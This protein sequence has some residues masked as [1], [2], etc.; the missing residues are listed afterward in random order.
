MHFIRLNTVWE[1]GL[2]SFFFRLLKGKRETIVRTQMSVK[3]NDCSGEKVYLHSSFV[4]V[5]VSSLFVL[6]ITVMCLSV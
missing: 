4:F 2:R 3:P 1:T 5:F 6:G